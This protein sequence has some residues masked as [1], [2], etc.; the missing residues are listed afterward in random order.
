MEQRVDIN[1]LDDA[2]IFIQEF[3]DKTQPIMLRRISKDRAVMRTKD[4]I[5]VIDPEE[6]IGAL[7]RGD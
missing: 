4:G 1:C 6:M 2:N 7:N 5:Y 3:G